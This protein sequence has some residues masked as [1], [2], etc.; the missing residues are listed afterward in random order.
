MM[1]DDDAW[2][3]IKFYCEV[4]DKVL[5]FFT[6]FLSFANPKTNTPIHICCSEFFYLR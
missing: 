5:L 4:R 2:D 3:G 1:L 6:D